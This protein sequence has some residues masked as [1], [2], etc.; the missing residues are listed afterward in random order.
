MLNNKNITLRAIEPYDIDIL[1]E[2]ENN[3][4]NWKVS[5]TF[6]P[7]SRKLMEE[8]IYNAQDLF[9]VKQIRFIIEHNKSKEQ[10]GCID[11]YNFD[12]FNLRAGVGILIDYKYRNK[13]VATEAIETLKK[14]CFNHLRLHQIY[15]SISSSNTASKNLFIK[16]NFTQNGIKKEWLNIGGNWEDELFFQCFAI[17]N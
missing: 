3:T 8:Y 16:S 4:E 11:L 13:G 9:S 1:L 7:F 2:W 17:N 12:P 15:C 6:V 14:Y 5:N 10:I